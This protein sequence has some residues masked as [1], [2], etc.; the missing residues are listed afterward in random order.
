MDLD[1]SLSW[2]RSVS[3]SP[4]VGHL[5][6]SVSEIEASDSGQRSVEHVEENHT[7]WPNWPAPFDTLDT[8]V[9]THCAAVA[10]AYVRNGT[11]MSPTLVGA[12]Y[13]SEHNV[14]FAQQFVHFMHQ[15]G[16]PMLV[17]TD[18]GGTREAP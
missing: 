15:H 5:P 12:N 7:C 16:V 14:P 1:S 11:W 9:V 8:A 4:F 18:F 3:L 13:Y 6:I 2:E 10:A 17:G